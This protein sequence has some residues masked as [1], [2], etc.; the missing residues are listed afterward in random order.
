MRLNGSK[1]FFSFVFSRLDQ[2]RSR[3]SRRFSGFAGAALAVLLA[4]ALSPR[5]MGQTS[6]AA[7]FRALPNHVP[8]WASDENFLEAVPAGQPMPALTLVLARHPDRERA[9]QKLLADQQDPSS[10]EFHHWLTPSEIG[11]RF[12]LSS[13]EIG[14]L[15]GWL[16]EQGLHVDWVTP[17]RNFIGFSGSA[18]DISQAFQTDLNYYNDYGERKIS[19]TSAPMIP[20]ELARLVKAIRGLYTVE[21]RPLHHVRGESMHPDAT[22]NGE[23]FVTP[24]DFATIY[25]LPG[26]LTGEGVT[27]GIVGRSRVDFADLLNFRKMTN[28]SFANPTE[29]VTPAK[30][31]GVD[32]GPAYTSPPGGD[33]STDD[34]LEAT[35]DVFRS[36][37]VAP[38]AKVLLVVN[39]SLSAGGSDIGGD[40]QY[41]VQTEPVPAQIMNVSF[42]ECES[43]AGPSTVDFWDGLFSQAAMEG[44]SVFVASGDAGASGCDSYFSTPPANPVPNSPNNICSSSHITCMGGTE[45]ND[46]DGSKYWSDTNGA[47]YSSALGYI[48]EGAW[49]EPLNGNTPPG[50]QAA[51]SG[52]GVSTVIPTPSWQK[53]TGVPA[54]RAGRYTPDLAFSASGHDGYFG[55]F[56]A[57]GW[58]CVPDSSG[59]FYFSYFF[60]TSAAA[61]DMAGVTALLDQKL[62]KAQGNLAPQVYSMAATAPKAFHDVTVS[63]SG[64]SSCTVNTPSMCNNS[65]PGPTGLTGGQP[66]FKVGTGYDE[67]TGLGS[68]NVTNFI[69]EFSGAVTAPQVTTGLASS[70]T[71][72]TATVAGTVNPEGHATQYWFLY[73]ESSTLASAAKTPVKTVSGSIAVKVS[74][75]LSGLL[76]GGVKYY[77]RLVASNSGGQTSGQIATFTTAKKSQTLTFPA[78]ASPV[79]YGTKPIA[80]SAKTSSGLPVEYTV[81]QGHAKVSSGKLEINGT[82]TMVIE[83]SQPGDANYLPSTSIKHS[84]VVTKAQLTVTAKNQTMQ[85]GGKVPELTYE[86]TGLVNG[87][88]FGGKAAWGTP[89]LTTTATSQSAPRKYPIAVAIGSLKA[90]N[91]TFKLVNG[92][93]TVNAAP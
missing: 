56:A 43:E 9:Y 57:D 10:P 48:P 11:E 4:G 54:A 78:P 61:P 50:T 21:E 92:T 60:G 66:G 93:L 17:A 25:D 1:S 51:A 33:V 14:A 53:G 73:G 30:F 91:Y 5:G 32:P 42:G 18:A 37:S 6:D 81:T 75:E 40:T 46:K 13:E 67:V 16:E 41:L 19:I 23:H 34:Q 59:E 26:N 24:A 68:L 65:I 79:K 84:I 2:S 15:T 38:K 83:A 89:T 35:L 44:I 52:G 39:K 36:A 71:K 76:P 69:N 63:S 62:G 88:K 45:F 77:Y 86:I 90:G 7:E 20:R 82:G 31:G 8:S 55:C 3:P 72:T 47:G 12:G 49:N 58:S 80:L 87:D 22:F 70:V 64:V 74:A 27:I 85:A 28:T 29:V